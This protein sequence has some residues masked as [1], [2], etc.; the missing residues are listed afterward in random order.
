MLKKL[1]LGL[2]IHI[3]LCIHIHTHIFIW[4]ATGLYVLVQSIFLLYCVLICFIISG[5]L[6]SSPNTFQNSYMQ[7]ASDLRPYQKGKSIPVK[8]INPLPNNDKHIFQSILVS[9]F[10]GSALEKTSL[11]LI[12]KKTTL[13]FWIEW[14]K[15]VVRRA[16]C[17]RIVKIPLL[18]YLHVSR[19]VYS[20][21]FRTFIIWCLFHVPYSVCKF[22]VH[23]RCSKRRVEAAKNPSSDTSGLLDYS[24]VNCF[25]LIDGLYLFP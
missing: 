11:H 19:V 16:V 24:N 8:S 14:T 4:E 10:K 1:T 20:C 7:N 9:V 15:S 12:S 13:N 3:Y 25:S 5:S 18:K 17:D 6:Y 22:T 21:V 2:L 23:L